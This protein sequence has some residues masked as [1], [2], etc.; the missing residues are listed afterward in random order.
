[1]ASAKKGARS[2]GDLEDLGLLPAGITPALQQVADRYAISVTE[3]L[4]ETI[5]HADPEGAVAR[6]YLPSAEE[7]SETPQELDDPI[8]DDAHSPVAGVVHRYDDRVLLNLLKTCAVYCRFCFRRESV[9]PG[10]RGLD[11]AQRA[12]ALDYIRTHEEIWEV[13]FSGGDP[14]TLSP[15]RLAE[16]LG[17][18]ATIPHVGLTRFHTR[19]PVAAPEMVSEDLLDALTA[20]PT[21]FVVLHVN[22]PDELTEAACAAIARI[23]GRGIPM[24]S[25]SVL[26][27]GI[28]DS[29]EVLG[30]L[31][32]ALLRNRVKPYYLHHG[33]LAR[34]TGH[35]RTS[36]AEGQ[37][38]IEA[39]RAHHSGLCIPHY[40]LDLPGGAGKVPLARGA[41]VSQDGARY[42]MRDR[43]GACHPYL[44]GAEER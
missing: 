31:F 23:V 32:K 39:L 35:F 19:V 41:V 11:S 27:K 26:L 12:A 10:S 9:G 44:D 22:H 4:S 18:L 29:E 33:D 42:R 1:M 25:Q 13:I 30:R 38:L 6:Q 24:L 36:I 14:L 21:A 17:D 16:V 20:G 8:G 5:L 7:L 2:L 40:V 15:R 34:G 28:N 37:D 43:H 3:S